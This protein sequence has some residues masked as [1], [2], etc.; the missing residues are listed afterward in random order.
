MF[1]QSEFA[2][3]VAQCADPRL[4]S[5]EGDHQ[6]SLSGRA[7]RKHQA[8]LSR[9]GLDRWSNVKSRHGEMDRREGCGNPMDDLQGKRL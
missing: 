3:R 7:S 2:M 5:R 9:A 1:S 8:A 4:R 6:L